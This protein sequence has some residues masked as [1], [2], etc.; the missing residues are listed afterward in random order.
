[1]TFSATS[2]ASFVSRPRYTSPMPPSPTLA[3]ISYTP[4]RAPDSRDMIGV[5]II[6]ELAGR[7]SSA[8]PGGSQ[9]WPRVARRANHEDRVTRRI[10]HA[11]RPRAPVFIARRV[12]DLH[13]V[14]PFAV[15]TVGV[16]DL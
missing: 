2:R 1:M 9:S 14:A 15:I 11:E 6:G 3:T 5:R 16:V 12:I 4:T 10:V 7:R 13:L 8:Q